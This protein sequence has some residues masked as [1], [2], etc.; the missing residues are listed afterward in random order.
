MA[1]LVPDDAGRNGAGNE[2][3]RNKRKS[4]ANMSIP[5][6]TV[7]HTNTD[8]ENIYPDGIANFTKGLQHNNLGRVNPTHFND[9]LEA[10]ENSLNDLPLDY[11]NSVS[12]F[13]DVPLL[14]GNDRRLWI[15]PVAGLSYDSEGLDTFNRTIPPHPLLQHLNAAAEMAELYWMA[16]IRD[17]N[18]TDYDEKPIGQDAYDAVDDLQNNFGTYNFIKG[19]TR[20]STIPLSVKTLFRGTNLG[21]DVGP[22]I[23]Q[24]MYRGNR[25]E[26]LGRE[27]EDGY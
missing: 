15:N 9:F 17:I 1:M 12:F 3:A 25:D 13:E 11:K 19:W 20:K 8:E 2:H 27:E 18:F 6:I 22:Y 10:V 26:S 14:V 5:T 16:L 23:S 21:D 7:I 4:V 24:F